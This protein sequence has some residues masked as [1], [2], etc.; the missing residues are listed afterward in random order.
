[1]SDVKLLRINTINPI[2]ALGISF[3]GSD[4]GGFGQNPSEQLLQRWYQTAIWTSFFRQHSDSDTPRREPYLYPQSVQENIRKAIGIRYAHLPYWYT[5][6]YEHYRTGEPVI[7]PLT[8]NY[9]NDTDIFDIDD[10]W[11]VGSSILVSPI[12]KENA[13]NRTVYLP[14]G[15]NELWYNTEFSLLYYGGNYTINVDI[16]TNLYFYRGGAVVARRDTFRQSTTESLNDAYT[17]YLFLNSSNA[18]TGTLY[19]DDGISFDYQNKH[20]TYRE[21]QY[22][23]GALSFRNIDSGTSYNGT[24]IIGSIVIYRPPSVFKS[25]SLEVMKPIIECLDVEN[26]QL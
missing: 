9:A 4:I 3:C 26:M 1:M 15:L 12:V 11:L 13:T 23:D 8:F 5:T 19:V 7:K 21:Y 2:I 10:E 16:G 20:Y 22:V 25:A 14:G 18:A 17:L 6:F 24:I